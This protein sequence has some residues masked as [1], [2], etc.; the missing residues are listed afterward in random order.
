MMNIQEHNVNE[1]E[2]LSPQR[3]HALL[4]GDLVRIP[5]MVNFQ[6]ELDVGVVINVNVRFGV[7]QVFWTFYER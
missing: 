6:D 1:L 4:P 2:R 3:D 7:V 5:F